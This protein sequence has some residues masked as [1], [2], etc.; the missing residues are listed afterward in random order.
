M[1]GLHYTANTDFDR[2][3]ISYVIN[4]NIIDL[5]YKSTTFI[6]IIIIIYFTSNTIVINN[7]NNSIPLLNSYVIK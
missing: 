5:S 4:R 6:R 3:F 2:S 1:T 7:L